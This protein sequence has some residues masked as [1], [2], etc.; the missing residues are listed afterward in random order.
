MKI[1][2]FIKK[3]LL[4]FLNSPDITDKVSV[5]GFSQGVKNVTFGGKNHVAARCNFAGKISVGYATTLGYNNFLHGDVTVGKYC[6]LGTDVAIHSTNHPST[7]LTTYI[8]KQLFDG[9]L[10]KLKQINK[11]VIGHDVWIGHNAIIVG[12]VTIGNGAIIAAG[13][14]VTKDVSPYSIVA[15]VPAKQLKKRFN[16]SVIAEISAL[17]WWDLSDSEIEKIRPLFFKDLSSVSS[18]Y[19]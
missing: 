2:S 15:G 19:D 11:I 3:I 1:R 17:H 13:A 4:Y 9:D 14:V 8:N 5:R 10:K 18:L 12:N 16:D 7:Y 6:Q